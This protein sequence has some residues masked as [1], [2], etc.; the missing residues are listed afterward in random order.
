MKWGSPN[1]TAVSHTNHH[2]MPQD[3]FL[4]NKLVNCSLASESLTR[5]GRVVAS[6]VAGG[7]VL[8][9]VVAVVRPQAA[10]VE[11]E[12]VVH[13]VRLSRDAGGSLEGRRA[14]VVRSV[15]SAPPDGVCRQD[16]CTGAVIATLLS[17]RV[18]GTVGGFT[19]HNV[20]V[21]MTKQI[22]IHPLLC[23]RGW[24]QSHHTAT[25]ER[26]TTDSH[27]HLKTTESL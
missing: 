4:E 6:A 11:A 5:A 21:T 10:V 8:E 2:V 1:T 24:S 3:T 26:Q 27:S 13:P 22:S 15:R 25:V 23:L 7:P 20:E 19:K 9:V 16:L 12:H 17:R 18:H 14:P